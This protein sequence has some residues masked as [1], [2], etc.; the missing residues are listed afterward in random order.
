MGISYWPAHC[1]YTQHY[2]HGEVATIPE[3]IMLIT[4]YLTIE[5]CWW[6]TRI[7]LQIMLA[8]GHGSLRLKKWG[9]HGCPKHPTV[10]AG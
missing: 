5:R 6:K 3:N 4:E 1:I 10:D 2:S 7:W 9:G 8:I